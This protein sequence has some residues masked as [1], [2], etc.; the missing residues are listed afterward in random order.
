MLDGHVSD[1]RLCPELAGQAQV[2]LS[3][4]AARLRPVH[5]RRGEGKFIGNHS[6]ILGGKCHNFF[7]SI[8]KV[9]CG[10]FDTLESF[11]V[12]VKIG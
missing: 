3:L 10:Y 9:I 6:E 11:N 4:P 1:L 7:I 12:I 2:R 5:R 8:S